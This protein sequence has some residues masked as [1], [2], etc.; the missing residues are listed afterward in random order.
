MPKLTPALFAIAAFA[1]LTPHSA[2]AGSVI[3]FEEFPAINNNGTLPASAYNSLGVTFQGTDDGSTFGG[4]GA[5]NP[6]NWGLEGTNGST[7]AGFNG[8]SYALN[9]LF[10]APVAAFS[11]D[12]SRANGSSNGTIT[13]T[14]FF[15]GAIAGTNA[16]N[17]GAIN[18]WSTLSLAGVFDQINIS[19]TG[20]G[21]HPFGI[22][23]IQFE[24]VQSA[25]PEPATW[26][27]MLLGFGLIG[28]AM[29]SVRRRTK[30]DLR[31]A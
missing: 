3:N 19:G 31:L 21:F 8:N 9:L 20:S 24:S 7:F 14:G 10:A 29:R 25:V 30:T 5:G 15:N 1:A 28:G 23:N 12:A 27:T 11:V 22:D 26:A 2:M 6:G 13:I 18:Q 17:L 4:N 16:V